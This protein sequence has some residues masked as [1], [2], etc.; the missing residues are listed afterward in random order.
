ME[1]KIDEKALL[2]A[3]YDSG[4]NQKYCIIKFSEIE[5]S[6][7]TSIEKIEEKF[8]NVD[9]YLEWVKTELPDVGTHIYIRPDNL[10]A[11]IKKVGYIF[12]FKNQKSFF[13]G[14]ESELVKMNVVL[15]KKIKNNILLVGNPGVGKT[16]LVEEFA[17]KNNL[18]NILFVECAKLIGN[19]EYRGSFE[20]KVV[21]LL[22]YANK[23]NLILF[24]DEIHS[25]V[26]LGKSTGGISIT[27]I[28]KP[29]LLDS[30]LIF[31]GA[32]T[33]KEVK[34]LTA[35]EAFK[36]RFSV[37][38]V[39]EPDSETLYKIKSNFEQKVLHKTI[40]ENSE[41]DFV[42]T[43]LQEKLPEQFFPDK[44]VDFLDYRNSF[45]EIT[46]KKIKIQTSLKDYIHDQNAVASYS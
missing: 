46:H 32:T 42:I 33:E 39:G 29:Y 22:D 2:N 5:S 24:F 6:D 1:D 17:V 27:D 23:N 21:D 15:N 7:F 34:Y 14:R 38:K 9:K 36:R 20:Q 4:K 13:T 3:I 16:C 30:K 18:H 37:I 43:E 44:L 8:G 12:D 19:S 26:D 11:L 10:P 45:Y 28:L 25:L 40:V 35:D 31:I 41:I